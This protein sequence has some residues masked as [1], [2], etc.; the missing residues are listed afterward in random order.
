MKKTFEPLCRRME[1]LD[2]FYKA[3]WEKAFAD[4]IPISGTFELT[5]RCNFNCRMCYVHLPINQ[6]PK[7]GIEM[8]G[9]EWIH[10][11]EA[12]KKAGTTWLC[13]TGGEPLVHPDFKEI[14]R[15]ISQ[16]GFFITLQTN[17]SLL[18]NEILDL[19][20]KYPPR[21]VKISLYGTDNETYEKVCRIKNGFSK[22][23]A[24]IQDLKKMNI[25]LELVST[26]IK[27][28]ENEL[29][30]MF[31]YAVKNRL[32]WT[33]TVGVKQSIRGADM[34]YEEVQIT[35]SRIEENFKE[36]LKY[37]INNA[38]L[39]I[40]RKPCTMCKDYRVG[41]WITWNGQMRFCGFMNEPDISIRKMTFGS[42]WKELLRYEE[43]L[44]WPNE[45]RA[46]KAQ[47]GCMRC[48]GLLSTASGSPTQISEDFCNRV[49]RY[50]DEKNERWKI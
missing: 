31:Y 22:V 24:G 5:P 32:K 39:D 23:D 20:E 46:C 6:I 50:Y 48:A 26:I 35:D 29:Y 9:I 49:K 3:V 42:A 47:A 19:F 4:R 34:R 2:P 27:Q 36:K 1:W 10:I 15:E 37:R 17:G 30:S 13:I 44:E 38:P 45:C 28:N 21:A 14:W 18:K 33:N 43:S 16:M 25:P 8:N 40:N 41:Y 11:A 7:Y 12:A